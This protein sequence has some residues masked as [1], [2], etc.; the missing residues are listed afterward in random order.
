MNPFRP[1]RV[2]LAEPGWATYS[3][4]VGTALFEAGVSVEPI[5]FREQQI[6]GGIIRIE[7]LDDGEEG[8]QIGPA[9]ELVRSRQIDADH[10]RVAAADTGV[11]AG[12]HGEMRLV[13]ERYTREEL[14]ALADR[15]GITGLR[16]IAAPYNIK[17]RSIN[18]LIGEIL[19]A[20]AKSETVAPAEPVKE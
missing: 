16:E 10:E 11:A 20:Q 9:A 6:I 1:R 15:R 13:A 14:E 7:S 4:H 2:R 18:E 12:S 8:T 3:G 5:S 19:E 17:G